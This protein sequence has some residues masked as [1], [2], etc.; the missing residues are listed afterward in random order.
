M[1]CILVNDISDHLPIF[2]FIKFGDCIEKPDIVQETYKYVRVLN[3]NTIG[4]YIIIFNYVI[5]KQ[6]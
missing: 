5:G 4:C 1:N 3:E 2:T 6:C